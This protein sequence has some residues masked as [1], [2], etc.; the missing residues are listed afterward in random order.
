M[1]PP[2]SV[3]PGGLTKVSGSSRYRF[4]RFGDL[5]IT[6]R[7]SLKAAVV[8]KI[9]NDKLKTIP[10]AYQTPGIALFPLK[11]H[12]QMQVSRSI[13]CMRR[14]NLRDPLPNRF[15]TENKWLVTTLSPWPYKDN[16]KE[17]RKIAFAPKLC[18]SVETAIQMNG[19]RA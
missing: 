10:N 3:E 13:V 1:S 2:E 9:S 4:E 6:P 7:L 16:M 11:R 17:H 18:R 8:Q 19:D 14:A 12:V 15:L 5:G